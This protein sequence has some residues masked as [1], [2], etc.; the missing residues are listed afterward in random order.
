MKGNNNND[1]ALH[2]YNH[3][4]ICAGTGMLGEA[5]KIA[6]D[7]RIRT[8]CYVEWEAYASATLVARMADKTLDN[9]P[10][11]DDVHSITGTEFSNFMDRV[12]RPICVT[13]GYPCQPFSVAG[14]RAG[15]NDP[16]HLWPAISAFVERNK[17]ELCFFENVSGH[18]RL[19]FD[20]VCADLERMGY[21]IA[22]GLFTA[23]EVGA[24][25]K[26]ERLFILA[27]TK[28]EGRDGRSKSEQDRLHILTG[29]SKSFMAN[30]E[31]SRSERTVSARYGE[32]ERCAT[33]RSRIPLFAPAP[34]HAEAWHK[35]L[36]IN[37]SVEPAVCR[38]AYGLANRVD[39]LRLTGNGVCTL[40]A[41]YAFLSLAATIEE[42]LT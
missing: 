26:R 27:H 12:L 4:D 20:T 22:A 40:A 11:W 15:E 13:A 29:S 33:E 39:R 16:R 8:A 17:P 23:A 2:T 24:A 28:R 1:M 35:I 25:H 42:Y 19:G 7:G 38:D 14:K 37:P 21:A 6:L 32:T 10:I 3:I 34:D 9:A 30:A 36:A 18:L 31:V 41:S 5:V